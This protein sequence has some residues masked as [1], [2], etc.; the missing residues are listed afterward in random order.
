[1]GHKDVGKNDEDG[2]ELQSNA[3]P[4]QLLA[5]IGA[6]A[7]HHRANS[8]EEHDK[9][10]QHSDRGGMIKNSLHQAHPL[11]ELGLCLSLGPE[12]RNRQFLAMAMLW[13]ET[14]GRRRRITHLKFAL[15]G[16]NL[17]SSCAPSTVAPPGWQISL[18]A[19]SMRFLA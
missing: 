2:Q 15:D 13:T 7:F 18:T 14:T 11:P 19:V 3:Q 12:D 1:V 5:E 16:K 6:R 4:H 17:N 9:Y 8:E 10:G